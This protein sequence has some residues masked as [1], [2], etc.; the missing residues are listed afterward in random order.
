MKFEIENMTCSGCARNVAKAVH[1]VDPDAEVTPDL[2]QQSVEIRTTQPA[3][4]IAAM[5]AQAGYPAV[6]AHEEA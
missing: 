5:L 6:E 1:A 3:F 2:A 4:S